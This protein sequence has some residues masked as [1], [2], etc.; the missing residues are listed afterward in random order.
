MAQLC[1]TIGAPTLADLRERRDLAAPDADLVELRL[2]TVADPDVAGALAGRTTPVVVTCRAAWEGGHFRGSEDERLRL[3]HQAWVAGAEFVDV[4]F[5]ARD[6]APWIGA[7]RGERLILSSHDFAGVPHD[8][9]ARHRAMCAESPAVVKIA[10][11]VERLAQL[12]PLA[13]LRAQAGQRQIVLGMGRPGLPTRLLP[14]R[15]GSAWTYAG[16]NWA[17]GQLPASVFRKTY[18]FGAVSSRAAVYGVV[19]R[20]SSHSVSPDMHNAAFAAAGL[21]AIYLPLEAADVDDLWTFSE[22]F[23][24][25]GASVTLPFKVDV[26][27]HVEADALSR[28]VGAANTLTRRGGRWMGTNTDVAGLLAPL[29]DRMTLQ[30]AR[31]SILGTGGA[32]RGAAVALSDAGARVTVFGRDPHK[33]RGVADL[34]GGASAILP[35]APGSWDLLVNATP[36]G[37]HPAIDESPWPDARFDGALVYDLIY[38]PRQTRLLRDAAAAGCA[39]LDGLPMLIAQAEAQFTQWTGRSPA[40]G[41]MLAAAE[42]RL[43]T[44]PAHDDGALSLSRS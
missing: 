42:A 9:T 41:V 20:P 14:D 15:F 22:A 28:R 23:G 44:F 26:L 4:E 11:T 13:G 39:T 30:G 37:M 40:P 8:L 5:A 18:R 38:N 31:A 19:A 27:P 34:V 7:T 33:A 3:L 10:V 32:A 29:T 24:L 12:G 21:D 6:A 17:P 1:V 43:A 25:Q 35:P 36:A 2:D 16:D